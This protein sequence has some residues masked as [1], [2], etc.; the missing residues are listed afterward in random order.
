MYY[1]CIITVTSTDDIPGDILDVITLHITTFFCRV[2]LGGKSHTHRMSL[3]FCTLSFLG[4]NSSAFLGESAK[5]QHTGVVGFSET[6]YINK[7]IRLCDLS[8]DR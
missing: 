3:G 7:F 5:Y 8:R 2:L 4:H 6:A 1:N